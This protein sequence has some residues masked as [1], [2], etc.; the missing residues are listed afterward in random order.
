MVPPLRILHISVLHAGKE[1]RGGNR[2][3]MRRVFGDAWKRN[4]EAIAKD[5][6]P[7]IVCFTGD[8]SQSGTAT[9]YS[10]VGEFLD[11][12]LGTLGTGKDRLFVV[13]GNHDVHRN[14]SKPEWLA[15]LPAGT[16]FD[17]EAGGAKFFQHLR[18]LTRLGRTFVDACWT[19]RQPS[20]SSATYA[21]C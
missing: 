1:D 6:R 7:N 15:P 14:T 8:L 9:E 21:A 4:L 12:L 13:P 17:I 3:R 2:W 11:D 16:R 18:C 20:K 10:Q 5:G 19:Y